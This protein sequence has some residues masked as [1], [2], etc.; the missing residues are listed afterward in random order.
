MLLT[1]SNMARVRALKEISSLMLLKPILLAEILKEKLADGDAG[2]EWSG[3]HEKKM[4]L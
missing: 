2:K 4:N 1:Q 3:K